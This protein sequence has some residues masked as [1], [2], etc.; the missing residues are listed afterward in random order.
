MCSLWRRK[1]LAQCFQAP[2]GESSHRRPYSGWTKSQRL[3]AE[4][5]EK[6][7]AATGSIS[8]SRN[9]IYLQLCSVSSMA[10]ELR[11]E[12]NHV[13]CC[14][15]PTVDRERD[16]PAS[17]SLPSSSTRELFSSTSC[18]PFP[19]QTHSKD[20]SGSAL[21]LPLSPNHRRGSAGIINERG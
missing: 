13:V 12:H 17:L 4:T 18:S 5:D 19:C 6:R 7:P 1:G 3:Q 11:A 16:G 9:I 10:T 14:R 15:G 8:R 21:L 2:T 20:D